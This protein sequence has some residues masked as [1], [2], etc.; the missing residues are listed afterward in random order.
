MNDGFCMPFTLIVNI[1]TNDKMLLKL[2]PKNVSALSLVDLLRKI[3]SVSLTRN[4]VTL[5][6]E[7]L[8]EKKIEITQEDK[9]VMNFFSKP[10]EISLDDI[11]LKKE[12]GFRLYVEVKEF[13]LDSF[14]EEVV[15]QKQEGTVRNILNAI[16]L[17]S[18]EKVKYEL[19]SFC[20]EWMNKYHILDI[21]IHE[22]ADKNEKISRIMQNY[23]IS[24]GDIKI[25]Y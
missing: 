1:D 6:K 4:F 11:T 22:I 12:N 21:I 8:A 10:I 25:E 19:I 14:M 3:E 13:N 20:F 15:M 17:N 18:K 23:N 5:L 2:I 7:I 24:I 16:N 9:V